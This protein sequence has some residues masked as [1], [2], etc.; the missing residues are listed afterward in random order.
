M[1][2]LVTPAEWWYHSSINISPFEAVYGITPP[3]HV[4]YIGEDSQMIEVD[5]LLRD[6]EKAM[7]V[8]KYHL[9]RAQRRMK[10]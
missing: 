5:Q 10:Q 8:M 1:A 9:E 6:G 4:P 7:K 3:I 2:T